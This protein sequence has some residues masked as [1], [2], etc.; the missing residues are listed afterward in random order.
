MHRNKI[1]RGTGCQQ[2]LL[3]S[4]LSPFIHLGTAPLPLGRIIKVIGRSI[5][6][7]YI[8]YPSK[9]AVWREEYPAGNQRIHD[10][11]GFSQ[12]NTLPGLGNAYRE[13]TPP[14]GIKR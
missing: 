13:R 9:G 1:N 8:P 6:D 11:H 7:L 2:I 10:V 12:L 14:A 5:N 3:Y 4:S